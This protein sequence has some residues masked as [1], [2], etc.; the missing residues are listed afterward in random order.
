MKKKLL[1]GAF[2]ISTFGIFAQQ[3]DGGIPIGFKSTVSSKQIDNRFFSTPNIEALRA[4]DAINDKAGNGPWRFGYNN[5][6]NLNMTNSGTWTSLPNGDKIWRLALVC[7]NASTVNLTFDQVTI[8]EGNE[9]Y[10]Y[11][12]EKTFILGKFTAY[13]LYEG[14]LGTELVPGNT[15]IIEY[16]VPS[17]NNI[18]KAFLNVSKVTHGYRTANEFQQKVFEESG[19]CNMNVNCPDGNLWTNQRNSVVMFV[20]NGDGF[21]T[22]ALINN[23]QNDGKPYIL[24]ANHCYNSNVAN[25]VFRFNWQAASCANPSTE[26]TFSSLSGAVLR[27]RRT[28]SDMCLIE[29]TGGLVNNTVPASYNPYFSGWDNSGAIPNSAVGIHHPSGDIKKI[30][31][32]DS[33]L[34]V[35][36]GM[37][38]SEANSTWSVTWDRNTTTEGGSS[39]SPLFDQNRR[40]V[41]QL[42]GGG[43]SCQNTSAVDYYGRFHNSWNPSGSNSTNHL[44]TWLD[45]TDLGA[46]IID[47]YDPSAQAITLD[48]AMSNPQGVSGVVCSASVTPKVTI[49]NTGSSILTS[50]TIHYGFNGAT[51][52]VYNWTGSLNQYASSQISL[53]SETLTT[54]TYTFKAIVSNPNSSTDQNNANDTIL[55]NFS[56]VTDG[57][58]ITLNLTLDCYGNEITWMLKN[59]AQTQTLYNGGPYSQTSTPTTKNIPFCLAEG[60]YKFI[61]NDNQNDGLAGGSWC[62]NGSYNIKDGANTTLVELTSSNANFGSTKTESF[63]IDA[64]AS[65]QELANSWEIYPNPTSTLLNLKI[66]VAGSK[67][68]ELLNTTG[69]IIRSIETSESLLQL[70]AHHLSK[71]MYVIRMISN[72]GTSQKTVVVN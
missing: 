67:T 57:H 31:F 33:P 6:T 9:L 55:S 63:C 30:S 22:G 70:D 14:N 18:G 28:P 46:E 59:D 61:I 2:L 68:I 54:G 40:I 50:A 19:N 13:H 56:I 3:G 49:V 38:S 11:N 21:C 53:P 52:L 29:I 66:A 10:I 17:K 4:E 39:G 72:E 45:P 58:P 24:T 16:Y 25:W 35:S 15:A 47:G 26:P 64:T 71:G 36:Q 60:C 51:N 7:E 44:K 5:L 37:S 32:D 41:G 42:W 69:Q 62:G 65:I 20:A 1:I 12:P 43:A 34:V 8:P 48:A 27:A 23:T